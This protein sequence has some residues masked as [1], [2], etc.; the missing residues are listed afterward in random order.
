SWI[1]PERD[2]QGLGPGELT[3]DPVSWRETPRGRVPVGWE[4]RIP[5][6]NVALTVA[7]PP[8]DYWNLGQFPYWESPVEVSGSHQGR[9]YMELTGY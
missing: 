4:I 1:T 9:G 7:A 5:G 6:Q 8:G 2:V 3:I